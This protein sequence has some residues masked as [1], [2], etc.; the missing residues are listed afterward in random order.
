M[1]KRNSN[2]QLTKGHGGLKPK[3]AVSKK[4]KLWEK[5]GEFVVNDGAEQFMNNIITLM[6]SKDPKEVALGMSMYKDT[7]EF[8]KPKLS[9]QELKA[10]V[11]TTIRRAEIEFKDATKP[12]GTKAV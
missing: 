6:S 10:N 8:F 2:G 1:A 4:T 11:E 5:L 7:I 12:I 3:G 9:R